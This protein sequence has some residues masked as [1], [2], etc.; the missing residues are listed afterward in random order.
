M[1]MSVVAAL[2][3]V[4]ALVSMFGMAETW[5]QRDRRRVHAQLFWKTVIIDGCLASLIG[6]MVATHA[7]EYAPAVVAV[8]A[9]AAVGVAAM[10]IAEQRGREIIAVLKSHDRAPVRAEMH[11]P[12]PQDWA[13]SD[14]TIRTHVLSVVP[15]LPTEPQTSDVLLLSDGLRAELVESGTVRVAV[16][17]RLRQ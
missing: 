14:T 4:H 15:P 9:L 11:A 1:A 5:A 2:A 8:V 12:T 6:V 3:V 7:L 13:R 16:D 10:V 17:P